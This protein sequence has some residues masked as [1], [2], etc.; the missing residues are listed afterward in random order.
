MFSGVPAIVLELNELTPTLMWR[1]MSEGRLPN[2]SRL[3]EESHAF[4]TDAGED[5]PRLEPWIQ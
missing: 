2:F 4:I 3:F 1:F 5:P